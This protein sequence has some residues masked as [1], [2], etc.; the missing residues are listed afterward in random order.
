MAENVLIDLL[1][2]H[3][4]TCGPFVFNWD[5]FKWK[6][7]K[8][9]SKKQIEKNLFGA[10]FKSGSTWRTGYLLGTRL[11]FPP[12]FPFGS[13]F[14]RSLSA[15]YDPEEL[16]TSTQ[17]GT[18]GRASTIDSHIECNLTVCD[19]FAFEWKKRSNT[20]TFFCEN[21]II[22]QKLCSLIDD[23]D[24]RKTRNILRLKQNSKTMARKLT[25]FPLKHHLFASPTQRQVT[26]KIK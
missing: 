6:F 5:V 18:C 12:L 13:N 9:P 1:D 24:R 11:N 16:H 8:K 7:N 19:M 4:F 25:H 3:T 20:T 23:V 21:Q 22:P 2:I 10:Y 26:G 15:E 14:S 17:C